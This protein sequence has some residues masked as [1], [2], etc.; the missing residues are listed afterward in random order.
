VSIISMVSLISACGGSS[1]S[2]ATTPQNYSGP[3]SKWDVNLA[4]DDTFIITR[5]PALNVA[6]DMTVTG[7]YTTLPTGFVRLTVGTS[8]GTATADLPAVGSEAIALEV[9]GYAFLLMP[10]NSTDSQMIPMISSGECP[11]V[12]VNANWVIVNGETGR[13][14]SSATQDFFGTFAF[15][16]TT[17]V[18][19]LPSMFALDNLFS[20]LTPDP[21]PVGAC[22]DGIMEISNGVMFLTSNGGAIVHIGTDTVGN[23]IDDSVIFALGQKAITDVANLDGNYAGILFDESN[24]GTEINPVKMSCTSGTCIGSI[25][26]D[27]T[28]GAIQAGATA[29]INLTGTPDDKAPGFITGTIT[30][31]SA[32]STPGNLACMADIDVLGSG[33]K[34]ISCVGQSP[35]DATKVKMFNVLF[36]SI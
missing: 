15:N 5:R 25:V 17:L 29:T 13:D 33:K 36:T 2:T 32:G 28:T 30:D 18:A 11:T 10:L 16:V 26:S 8:S 35:G 1:S 24:T 21:L 27:I 20:S 7:T 12:D 22:V 31:N 14:A 3:G 9:P 34:I 4:A 6:V 23:E 19:S